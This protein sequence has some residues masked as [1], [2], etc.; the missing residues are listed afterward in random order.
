MTKLI[1]DIR[2]VAFDLDGT[3]VDTAPDLAAAA[4]TMLGLLGGE[5]LAAHRIRA[6]IGGGTERF[7]LNVLTHSLKGKAPREE[8]YRAAMS[9]FTRLYLRE[10]SR[11]ANV[12]PGVAE[13]LQALLDAGI[14]LCCVT[15]KS[16]MFALPLLEA[17]HLQ[18]FFSFTLCADRPEQCKP[19]PDLLLEACDRAGA[20]PAQM[21]YVGDSPYDVAA[22]RAA[23]CGMIIVDYGYHQGVPFGDVRPDAVITSLA[24]I[25][26]LPARSKIVPFE[27][28][29]RMTRRTL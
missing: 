11:R 21:L 8:L 28:R 7:V 23:G 17:A 9:L 26:S 12:Y 18:G 19:S 20:S 27:R 3:L 22:A 15:N 1:K 5:G 6:S 16:S 29:S 2:I 25:L 10:L 14:F 4:N 24:E 13:G